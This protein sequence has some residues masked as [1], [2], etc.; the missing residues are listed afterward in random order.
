MELA[1]D[2]TQESFMKLWQKCSEVSIEKAQGFVFIT[3]KNKLLNKIKHEKVKIKF[4]QAKSKSSELSH[5]SPEYLLQEKEFQILLQEAIS[6]LPE[7]QRVVFLMSRIDKLTYKEIA[8]Q[9]GISR[10]AVEKRIYN[11]LGTLQKIHKQIK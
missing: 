11:A 10:Q 9:L 6:G 8:N 1:K 4:A 7:K 3:A 2:L 5:E